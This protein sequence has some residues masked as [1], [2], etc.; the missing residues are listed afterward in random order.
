MSRLLSVSKALFSNVIPFKDQINTFEWTKLSKDFPSIKF[1]TDKTQLFLEFQIESEFQLLNSFFTKLGLTFSS[2][3]SSLSITFE[4]NLVLPTFTERI[5]FDIL[6]QYYFFNTT[7]D[8]N[9]FCR[10]VNTIIA[11]MS[12]HI[13]IVSPTDDPLFNII[14]HLKRNSNFTAVEPFFTSLGTNKVWKSILSTDAENSFSFRTLS[15]STWL[16]I[17]RRPSDAKANLKEFLIK[18]STMTGSFSYVATYIPLIDPFD[19]RIFCLTFVDNETLSNSDLDSNDN[20]FT[21]LFLYW[22]TL[23]SLVLRNLNY[24]L[25]KFSN[26]SLTGLNHE[27]IEFYDYLKP[28]MTLF[29]E[30]CYNDDL[31][32]AYKFYDSPKG[33]FAYHIRGHDLYTYNR[34][35]ILDYH[36]KQAQNEFNK[37]PH[38]KILRKRV[39]RRSNKLF[40]FLNNIIVLYK[41]YLNDISSLTKA[42]GNYS[43]NTIDKIIE[44]DRFLN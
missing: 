24:A 9:I 41:D 39:N 14:E 43:A 25:L 23:S 37:Y 27:D 13:R 35:I 38:K 6:F 28:K 8:Y 42:S 33:K 11:D 34:S 21:S 10:F 22:F 15:I 40:E 31:V 26:L 5:F 12:T 1:K 20:P 7:A 3:P 29:S 17:I 32:E 2:E 19:K 30:S 44:N 16:H 18:L 36:L 4:R